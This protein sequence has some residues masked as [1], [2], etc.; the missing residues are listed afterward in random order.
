M[1]RLLRPDLR[2]FC[3]DDI[4]VEIYDNTFNYASGSKANRM[5][6][7]WQAANDA[8]VG[9]SIEK[10]I[11]NIDTQI[12]LGRMK[13]EDFPDELIRRGR[14]IAARLLGLKTIVP[15]VTESEFITRE[16]GNVSID[17]IGLIRHCRNTQAENRGNQVLSGSES[18]AGNYIPLWE[19]VGGDTPRCRVYKGEGI[20][21]ISRQPKGQST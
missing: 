18:S 17:K 13:R 7:F 15:V 16:F 19:Y 4:G 5:R 12:L 20:Q 14:D 10:L 9:K 6:G 21:S 11:G 3:R 2:E 8:L 1:F